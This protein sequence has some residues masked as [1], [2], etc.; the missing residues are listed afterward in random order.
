MFGVD[1]KVTVQFINYENLRKI[2]YFL[3]FFFIF[4]N[5]LKKNA[6]NLR[7]LY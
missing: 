1:A 4:V 7:I 2:L 5:V 3:S 6:K